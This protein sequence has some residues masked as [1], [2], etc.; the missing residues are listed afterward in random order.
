MLWR[1]YL[2]NKAHYLSEYQF[3]HNCFFGRVANIVHH[4][5]P[6]QLVG[7]FELFVDALRLGKLCRQSGKHPIC[8][9][10]NLAKVGVEPSFTEQGGVPSATVLLDVVGVHP[11][12]FADGLLFGKSHV[13]NEVFFFLAICTSKLFVNGFGVLHFLFLRTFYFIQSLI[14]YGISASKKEVSA[15]LYFRHY[16]GK[17]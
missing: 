6:P 14:F 2:G 11:P 7:S 8:L 16:L 12:V 17:H 13:G 10:V 5:H 4:L 1:S 9:F 3:A 15:L